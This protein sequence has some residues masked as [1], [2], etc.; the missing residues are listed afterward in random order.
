MSPLV[1]SHTVIRF[2]RT[3]VARASAISISIAI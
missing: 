2:E 3:A 1:H